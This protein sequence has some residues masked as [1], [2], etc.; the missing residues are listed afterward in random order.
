MLPSV[1]EARSRPA[2]ALGEIAAANGVLFG[3]AYDRDILTPGA[4]SDL[5]VRQARILTSNNFLKFGSLRPAEGVADFSTADALIDFARVR[6]MYVRGH[7]L[8]WN[9]WAPQWL[10]ASSPDRIAYWLDRHIDETVSRYAGHIHS[11]DVVNEPFWVPHGNEGGY[12]SGPW[13]AAL[14]KGYV[15]RALRRAA[16]ADPSAKLVINESGPEWQRYWGLDGAPVRQALLRLIDE[17]QQQGARLDAIG[18]QCHWLP[19]FVFDVGVF[20]DFLGQLA[21]RKLA[22]YITE[23]DVSDAK[24][25]GSTQMRDAEVARRYRLLVSA[26]LKNPQVEVVQTWELS[27]RATWLRARQF[28]G[29]RGRLTR[30]LPFDDGMQ[31]KAACFALADVLAMPRSSD[32][33]QRS[34]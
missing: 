6:G 5:Y 34:L 20:E 3:S 10:Q 21:E 23:M 30:P 9:E 17:L 18:L 8:I 2:P 13:L 11:W 19:D 29:P 4:F 14:G 1:P 24:L 7:N 33:R 25:Q 28:L 22:I 26:A 16:A 12:R 31:P 15:A 27:D 32:A